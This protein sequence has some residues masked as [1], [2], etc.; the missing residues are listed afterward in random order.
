MDEP[1]LVN[2]LKGKNALGH[3]EARYVFAKGVVLDEHSHEIS[4][5]EELHEE[6][7]VVGVLER[8]VELDDPRRVGF[9]E[10]VSFSA[11]VGELL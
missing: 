11:Y 7:E 10:D 1:K 2:G 5:G 8:V 6:V 3:V 4:S 9:G